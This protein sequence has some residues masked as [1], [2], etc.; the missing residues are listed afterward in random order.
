MPSL[1]DTQVRLR[2]ALVEGDASAIAPM[3]VG[4]RDPAQRVAIHRRHY[5]KS[6]V[7]ALLGKF[8]AVGWLM[9]QRFVTEAAQEFIR[10]RPPT[11][12]CIAEYGADFPE[13]LAERPG[14]EGVPYLRVFAELEWQLGHISI[15]VDRPALGIDAFA[16]MP[17]DAVPDLTLALQPGLHYLLAPWPIDDL[18]KL[19]LTESAPEHYVFEPAETRIEVCGARG[20]FDIKRVDAGTFA[21]RSAIGAGSSIGAAAERAL[22]SD[23]TFDPGRAFAALI[24]ECLVT[25]ITS[26][27]RRCES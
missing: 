9:G 16:T 5:M 12:P 11:A 14:A 7:A 17:A 26:A 6:L 13:L 27:P 19:Y 3:L 15:A 25:A 24:D 2:A 22:E 8:P 21:F 10:R 18:M 4:G 1:A 23:A 20:K